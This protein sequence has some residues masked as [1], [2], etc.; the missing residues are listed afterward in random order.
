AATTAATAAVLAKP[1]GKAGR[2][3]VA[4]EDIEAAKRVTAGSHGSVGPSEAVLPIFTSGQ[5]WRRAAE[6][7]RSTTAAVGRVAGRA[8]LADRAGRSARPTGATDDCGAETHEH[9]LKATVAFGSVRGSGLSVQ[10]SDTALSGEATE[11]GSARAAVAGDNVIA[12]NRRDAARKH[13]SVRA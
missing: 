1:S 8:I 10:A 6:S 7:T 4:P 9:S 2:V 13:H 5:R 3:G 11:A 12:R